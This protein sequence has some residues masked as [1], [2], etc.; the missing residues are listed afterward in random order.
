MLR[1]KLATYNKQL[2][3]LL[4]LVPNFLSFVSAKYY[5]NWLTVEKVITKI[6][7]GELF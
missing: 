6:K 1:S 7:K 2:S 5:L 3:E 4:L